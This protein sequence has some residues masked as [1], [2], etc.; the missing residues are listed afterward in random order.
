[1]SVPV[2]ASRAAWWLPREQLDRF[3]KRG[4]CL[5]GIAVL[6]V[7]AQRAA[8][9]RLK[10]LEISARLR[11]EQRPERVRHPGNRE[12]L[13]AVGGDLQEQPG[14]RTALVELAG[15]VQ[16]ARSEPDRARQ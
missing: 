11:R 14:I 1:P 2:R 10:D 8:A 7:H 4:D 6:G 12:V 15:G 16:E 13:A 9:M 3:P 5:G